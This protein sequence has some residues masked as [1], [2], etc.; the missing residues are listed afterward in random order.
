MK[1]SEITR[2]AQNLR[3]N[4]LEILIN[5]MAEDL[6]NELTICEHEQM[7]EI[8]LKLDLLKSLKYDMIAKAKTFLETV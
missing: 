5:A 8:R 6:K 7:Y 4:D 3:A 2:A 1:P